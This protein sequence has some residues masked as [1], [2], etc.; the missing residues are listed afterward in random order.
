MDLTPEQLAV[1]RKLATDFEFFAPAVL[2]IVSQEGGLKPFALTEQQKKLH[3]VAERQLRERGRVRII[4]AKGRKTKTST[5]VQGRF[6]WR[7]THRKGVKAFVIAHETE[8]TN[9]L[10]SMTRRFYDYSP[11]DETVRPKATKMGASEMEFGEIG[12]SYSTGT[13]GNKNVGL[14]FTPHYLHLSEVSRFEKGEEI[15]RGLMTAVADVEGTEIWIESTG[16]GPGDYFHSQVM[17]ALAGKSDFEVVFLEWWLEANYASD[18]PIEPDEE[19]QKLLAAHPRL[20]VRNLAWRRKRIAMYGGDDAARMLFRREF[21]MTLSDVFAANDASF[22]SPDLVADAVKR[23]DHEV[24]N[25]PLV[26]GIDPGGGGTDPTAVVARKGHRFVAKWL[27]NDRDPDA[28]VGK[29]GVILRELQPKAVFVDLIGVGYHLVGR[30]SEK[31]PGVRGV[32]FRRTAM[33]SE[34]YGNKRAECYGLLKEWLTQ[35]SI[36]D[37]PLLRMELSV[38]KYKRRPNGQLM[39]EAKEDA[40][41]RGFKSPNICDALALTVSEPVEN[42]IMDDELWLIWPHKPDKKNKASEYLPECNFITMY[43][44][45]EDEQWCIAIVGVFVPDNEKRRI[46]DQKTEKA[47]AIVLKVMDGK[48]AY[49]FMEAATKL[50]NTYEPDYF[51][52]PSRIT[53]LTKDLRIKNLFVRRATFD[54]IEDVVAVG[55]DV[56]KEKCAWIRNTNSGRQFASRLARYPNGDDRALYGCIGLSLAH[57]RQRGNLAVQWVDD[58]DEAPRKPRGRTNRRTAY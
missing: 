20:T 38:F 13:A 29:I 28:V 7:V 9:E 5:Y 37:D 39:I 53:V 40:R 2:K 1:R 31:F 36:P 33:L 48:G 18:E 22:I 58:D 15:A 44:W 24:A 32:D 56:L 52:V 26:V 17:A 3:E 35:A 4:V 55:H 12:T 50:W 54:R 23:S 6:Y 27:I 45:L 8:T 19:E 16:N 30:L 11:Q 51:Y 34:Q 42:G 25:G 41:E 14:G 10:F 49:G 43:G 46:A 57:L 21:P 47:N